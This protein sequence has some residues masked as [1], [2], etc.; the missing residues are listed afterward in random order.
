MLTLAR[1]AGG[2][3]HNQPPCALRRH[4]NPPWPTTGF[5]CNVCEGKV[6]TAKPALLSQAEEAHGTVVRGRAE[7]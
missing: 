6:L 1:W 4:I 2:Q 3:M 7:N 5:E